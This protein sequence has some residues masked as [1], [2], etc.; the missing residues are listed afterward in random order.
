VADD[1]G[2]LSIGE[3]A[4]RTG[5]SVHTLRFYEQEGLLAGPVPRSTGGRRAY[6]ATHV[7]LLEVC[8]ALRASGMPLGSIRRFVDLVRDG[9]GSDAELTLL[10]QHEDRL[11]EE[12]AELAARLAHISRKI[13]LYE[14]HVCGPEAGAS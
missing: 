1:T 2:S 7:E 8:K 5:L 14:R 4:A 3:V 13:G 6:S 11:A 12:S 10:R 9:A